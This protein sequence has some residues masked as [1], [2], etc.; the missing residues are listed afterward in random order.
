MLI[1]LILNIEANSLTYLL[2]RLLKKLKL[3]KSVKYNA[4]S[5]L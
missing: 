2:D 5:L 3:L 1:T 4:I